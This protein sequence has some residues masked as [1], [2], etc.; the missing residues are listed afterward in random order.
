MFKASS[1]SFACLLRVVGIYVVS[2]LL[3]LS[4][5][6]LPVKSMMIFFWGEGELKRRGERRWRGEE[7]SGGRE[8]R[9]RG[10]WRRQEERKGVRQE[11]R[12]VA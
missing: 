2:L 7:W 11:K 1:V 3:L 8:D 5:F 6:G 10:E 12:E 9:K 4:Y